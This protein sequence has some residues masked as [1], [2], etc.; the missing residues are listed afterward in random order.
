MCV[1]R[2]LFA[3]IYWYLREAGTK[4]ICGLDLAGRIRTWV[5]S[6]GVQILRS[7]VYG[8]CASVVGHSTNNLNSFPK[9]WGGVKNAVK[10][11][12]LAWM[13]LC[14]SV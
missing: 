11:N 8:Y 3:A 6:V 5:G 7:R 14:G 9:D 1:N 2:I 4:V 10:K 13:R 12:R